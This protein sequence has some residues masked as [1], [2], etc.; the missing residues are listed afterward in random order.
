[1]SRSKGP[2]RHF[3]R[4]ENLESRR[5]MSGS[6][7]TSAFRSYD[8]TGNNLAHADWGSSGEAQIRLVANEY[9]DG[10]ST[11]A[12]SNRA[13]ARAISNAVAAIGTEET[14]S[15]QFLSAYAYAWGQFLD[16]DLVLTNTAEPSES[17]N[18]AVPTGDPYFDPAA[19]GTQTIPLTRS[20]YDP[21]SGIT[22]PRQQMNTNTAFIDASMIYGSDATRARALRT[23][24]GG[25]MKTSAGDLMPYNTLGLDNIAFGPPETAFVAGDIRANE[26]PELISLH[27]LF[28]REHNRL[29]DQISRANRRLTDEQV[30]QQARRLVI[31]I[32]QN[33]TYNEFLPSLMGDNALPTYRGYRPQVNAGISNEFAT[34]GYRLGHSLLADD[35]EFMANDGSAVREEISLAEGFF[36]P[37]IV[38]ETGIDPLLKYLASSN[39]QEIDTKLVD[40]LRNFLFGAPGQGGL[41]L[42]SLNIQRGRD[43]GLADYNTTRVAL[44]LPAV[45]SFAQITSD[46]TLQQSLQSVYGTVNDID[47]W[48][49]GLAEDHLRGSSLGPT[50]QRIVGDQFTRS[51]DGDRFFFQRDLRGN[52]LRLAQS[53]TLAEVIKRNS[54]VENIQPDVFIFRVDVVGTVFSDNNG[55]GRFERRERG[56]GGRTLNLLDDTGAIVQTTTTDRAG[57]YQFS[58]LQIGDYSVVAQTQAG[59]TATTPATF[60]VDVTR[61]QRFVSDFGQRPTNPL[62]PLPPPPPP[63][64]PA[65]AANGARP[66][67]PAAGARSTAPTASQTVLGPDRTPSDLLKQK[68]ELLP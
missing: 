30:Y 49:G 64:A 52:D 56:L 22:T 4:I 57:R 2:M 63:P 28:L 67:S 16:H 32:V 62:P 27:S 55:N 12:G 8:G 41:D 11:P 47:L 45:T 43:H 1:M 58:G 3:A 50:F 31:G 54:D 59:F 51:R 60:A 66:V 37:A 15:S 48:V 35:I 7:L 19:T 61:G 36:N 20:E 10:I 5:L 53:S 14:L 68:G 39:S 13:S 21:A 29:A 23:L 9:G 6:V 25:R 18:V 38:A 65:T 17:F 44:G 24:S 33:I 34:A 42:A 46:L 40:S 26:N